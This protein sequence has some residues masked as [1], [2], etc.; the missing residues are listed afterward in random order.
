ML[1]TRL[2][3]SCYILIHNTF[4]SQ[5]SFILMHFWVGRRAV[6]N[7]M[8]TEFDYEYEI[9]KKVGGSVRKVSNLVLVLRTSSVKSRSE[10]TS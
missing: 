8:S 1:E 2:P 7:G 3:L 10:K 9:W 4:R 6:P 5:Q